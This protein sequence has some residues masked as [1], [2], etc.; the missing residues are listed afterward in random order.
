MLVNDKIGQLHR[1]VERR[2]LATTRS[3]TLN[4]TLTNE[5]QLNLHEFDGEH[6]WQ[7]NKVDYLIK[8]MIIE[9]EQNLKALMN[10]SLWKTPCY[11]S[12]MLEKSENAQ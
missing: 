6:Y 9:L 5:P 8:K 10:L 11:Y 3:S 1:W 4:R 12:F 7:I 2:G